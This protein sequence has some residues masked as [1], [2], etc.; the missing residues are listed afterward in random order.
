MDIAE[1]TSLLKQDFD[2][3][4]DA[5]KMAGRN[6]FWEAFLPKGKSP[7]HYEFYGDS[8]NEKTF[9]PKYDLVLT[10][11]SSVFQGLGVRD[12]ATHL[13]EIGIKIDCSQSTGTFAYCFSGS[14]TRTLPALDFSKAKSLNQTFTYMSNLVEFE[15]LK[16]GDDGMTTFT[17]PFLGCSKLEKLIVKG[18]IGQNISFSDCSKLTYESL[19][20][21]INALYNYSGSGTTHTLTLHA[22][23][24]ARLSDSEK[25]IA[26]QKGWTI[27]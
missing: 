18:V 25:V 15:E 8:W 14:Y 6:D 11:T 1:K 5:G 3:V 23:A 20:S 19:M 24:K 9:T 26:T 12:L 13:E 27:A 10:N 17:T 4:Y 22:D 7:N 2:D 16:L 21:I